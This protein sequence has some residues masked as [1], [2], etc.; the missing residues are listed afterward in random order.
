M[1][2]R[3]ALR[4]ASS[5]A[6]VSLLQAYRREDLVAAMDRAVRYYQTLKRQ[7]TLKIAISW[8]CGTS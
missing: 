2:Y 6:G 1:L 8:S 5:A 3:S 4:K 7:E